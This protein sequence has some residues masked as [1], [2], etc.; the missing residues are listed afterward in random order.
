MFLGAVLIFGALSLF[1][2]NQRE[3]TQAKKVTV[4][5][6]PQLMEVIEEK[7]ASPTEPATY[8]QPVGTPW[9]TWTPVP[10]S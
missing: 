3:D 6:M 8:K 1:L 5:L 4:E 2:Y 9:N 10:L 7:E